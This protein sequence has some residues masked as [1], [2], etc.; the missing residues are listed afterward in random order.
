M[1][2]TAKKETNEVKQAVNK[3]DQPGFFRLG[4]WMFNFSIDLRE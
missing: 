1:I 3:Y 2:I 4:S